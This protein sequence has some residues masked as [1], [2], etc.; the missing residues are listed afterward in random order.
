MPSTS[1]RTSPASVN[2]MAFPT[3]L[4][5]TWV[6]RRSSPLALG[7]SAGTATFSA[8]FFSV[9]RG[10][11]LRDGRLHDLLHGIVCEGERERSRLDFGQIEDI[12]DQPEEM[13]PVF[14]H[15]LQGIPD[16]LGDLAIDV[17]QDEFRIAQDRV[18]R[19]A[20]LVAHV[21]EELGLVLAG[22]LELAALLLDLLELPS[23]LDRQHGLGREGPQEIDHL[24]RKFP[25][26]LATHGE[27]TEDTI[28]PQEGNV[29]DR[30]KS[31]LR[32]EASQSGLVGSCFNIGKRDR[33]P[34]YRRLSHRSFAQ[35]NG[36][37]PKLLDDLVF[38]P[39][40]CAQDEIFALLVVFID[41]S[42]IRPRE[43]N[44]MGGDGGENRLKIQG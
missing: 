25:W 2:L 17:V 42:P 24:W 37:R 29:Q 30:L 13:V 31:G 34:G 19:R 10:F 14:V 11:R 28:S 27:P 43:L 33:L 36:I 22:D 8:S 38:H 39:V 23:V 6:I 7:R 16:L 44:S 32:Q 12:V 4:R 18:Q 15:A 40:R 21:G 41:Q 3:R 1:T 5:S 20:Q 35:S 9:A 26:R